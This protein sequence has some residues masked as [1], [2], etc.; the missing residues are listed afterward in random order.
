MDADPENLE[1]KLEAEFEKSS[2][3]CG[4]TIVAY[5]VK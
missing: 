4:R 3:L 1:M 2:G 5:C